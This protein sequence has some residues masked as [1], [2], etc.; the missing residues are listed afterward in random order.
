MLTTMARMFLLFAL[1][2]AMIDMIS[3]AAYKS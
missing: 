2:F 1:T 3:L